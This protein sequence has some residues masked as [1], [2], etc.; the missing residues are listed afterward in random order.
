MSSTLCEIFLG[1]C[2]IL[3]GICQ[4]Y[5]LDVVDPAW[6]DLLFMQ[7]LSGYRS[8]F[9]VHTTFPPFGFWGVCS[10]AFSATRVAFWCS[11]H[12]IKFQYLDA[13]LP[14]QFPIGIA[15]ANFWGSVSLM[16]TL[17]IPKQ[18]PIGISIGNFGKLIRKQ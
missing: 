13:I 3:G 6:V 17:L 16:A 10:W 4:V 2:S 5:V 18:F 12:K 1:I 8:L 7:A 11:V 14:K 15:I 9:L